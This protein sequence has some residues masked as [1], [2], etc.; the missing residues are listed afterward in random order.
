MTILFNFCI[1]IKIAEHLRRWL[2]V[3]EEIQSES[4]MDSKRF[5]FFTIS[6]KITGRL[7]LRLPTPVAGEILLESKVDSKRLFFFCIS[8]N[9]QTYPAPVTSLGRLLVGREIMLE[10]KWILIDFFL[11][12]NTDDQTYLISITSTGRQRDCVRIQN[13]FW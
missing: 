13:I 1:S 5:F 6:M 3:V 10:F 2:T 11:D 12:F 8:I 4:K 7:R 9:N